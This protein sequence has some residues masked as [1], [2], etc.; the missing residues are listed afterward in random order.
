MKALLVLQIILIIVFNLIAITGGFLAG[1]SMAWIFAKNQSFDFVMAVKQLEGQDMEKIQLGRKVLISL[2]AFLQLFPI[3]EFVSYL[4]IYQVLK[5]SDQSNK[6]VLKPELLMHR[7]K[8]NLMTL[9]SQTYCFAGETFLAISSVIFASL[10]FDHP[11][12]HPSMFPIYVSLSCLI[13][14][15]GQIAASPD[16]RQYCFARFFDA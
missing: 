2:T 4:Y 6:Q 12:F 7:R 15:I 11:L 5:K 16:L 13:I 3:S 8:R 9:A 14:T 1:H 10:T